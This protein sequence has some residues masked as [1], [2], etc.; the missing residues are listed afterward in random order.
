MHLSQQQI[1]HEGIKLL[2]MHRIIVDA[3]FVLVLHQ[4]FCRRGPERA[5]RP[6]P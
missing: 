6:L 5:I 1:P 4:E 2:Q 3:P